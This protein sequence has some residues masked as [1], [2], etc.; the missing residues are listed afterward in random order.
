MCFIINDEQILVF[1]YPVFNASSRTNDS[2]KQGR[3]TLT[4]LALLILLSLYNGEY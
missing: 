2:L 3:A 4:D 1:L